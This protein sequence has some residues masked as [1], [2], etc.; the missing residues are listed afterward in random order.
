MVWKPLFFIGLCLFSSLA[1]AQTEPPQFITVDGRL[2][3]SATPENPLLDNSVLIKVQVLNPAKTCV[4]YEEEQT[5]ST[6]T[7][8]GYFNIRVGSPTSGADSLKRTTNDSG[9]TMMVV[10]QNQ[11]ASITGKTSAGAGCGYTP[12]AGD[13]RYFRFIV[14]PSSTGITNTLSPD[15]TIDSV[16]QS[17]VAETLQGRIPTDFVQINSD[18]TQ[19]KA[20]SLFGTN[21]TTLTNLL[22]GTSSLYLQNTVNGT[23]I[24]NRATD[25]A[26]PVA[27]Q[28]W[29]DTANGVMKYYDGS[30]IQ[31]FGSSFTNTGTG[32]SFRVND[33]AG[34]TSPFVIDQSG[35][36]GVGVSAPTAKVEAQGQIV[37]RQ[38]TIATGGAVDFSLGN[39]AVLLSVGG[40]TI[41]LS[42][43]IPG[44]A[45]T[46]VVADTTQRTYTFAGCTA[47]YFRPANGIT[48]ASSQTIYTIL[49]ADIGGSTYC[50]IAW[51]TG[52]Q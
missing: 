4:L 44:G 50:Y 52:F 47:T 42:N 27:G 8:N 24:P 51:I 18:V 48:G 10:F 9:N 40:S 33:Q 7:S 49:A 16:P 22:A 35:N 34:D 23:V 32:D 19:A 15:M 3:D 43:M 30:S 25:P 38:N 1:F 45:Y 37:S 2:Y 6:L 17:L 28:I 36:L 11:A 14:T 21:Y 26:T 29:Y 41:T 39:V 31:M 20:N 12:T 13:S 5:V 46:V